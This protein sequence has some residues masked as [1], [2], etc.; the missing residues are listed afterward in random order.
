[1]LALENHW[2]WDSWYCWQGDLLHAFYLK[3]P[4]SLGDPNLRHHNAFV[5]HSTSTDGISWT[6]H[7][8]ALLP[9]EAGDFDDLAIWT[10]SVLWHDGEWHLFYTGIE[11]RT[12]GRV[13]RIGH[14]VSQD[15][16]EWQ[17]VQDTPILQAS[18]PSYATA[19]TDPRA[20]EPFRDPWVFR[21]DDEWHMLV[22]ARSSKGSIGRGNMAH[23]TSSDLNNWNLRSP[24]INDSGFEQLEVFQ[25]VRVAGKWFVIFCTGA[26]DIHRDDVEKC[27]ATYS[28]PAEGPLGPFDLSQ[29]TPITPGGGVY[30]GRVVQFP[31]E[32]HRLLGF[33]DNGKLGGFQGVIC[34]PLPLVVNQDGVL[35][36]DVEQ[37][38]ASRDSSAGLNADV[39]HHA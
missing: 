24:L 37:S 26:I 7:A 28:A 34:D 21:H 22:T 32:S 4:K 36:L 5:G 17:R 33:L 16:F 10:G 38:G 15:L 2:V 27:Y 29:A 19:E 11:Q 8:D 9:G 35:V 23:A 31:D 39:T 30:A 12:R 14:A 13:Q 20:E 6:H 18:A 3:A 1:M 25:I